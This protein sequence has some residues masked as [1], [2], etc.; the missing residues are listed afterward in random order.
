MVVFKAGVVNEESFVNNPVPLG[1]DHHEYPLGLPL[2]VKVVI[3]FAFPQ[4]FVLPLTVGAVSPFT[5]TT[6][7]TF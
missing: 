2:A 6:A 3:A 1:L 7:G 5:V 4:K